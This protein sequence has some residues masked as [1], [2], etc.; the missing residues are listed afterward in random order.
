MN[1]FISIIDEEDFKNN[2]KLIH[3]RNSYKRDKAY[4][5]IR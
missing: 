2:L 4:I 1:F 5:V 3:M